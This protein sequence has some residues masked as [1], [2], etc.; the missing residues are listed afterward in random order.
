MGRTT[1]LEDKYKASRTN[2][3]SMEDGTEDRT[4][5]F[6]Y[7]FRNI[8]L[9][10]IPLLLVS[11]IV[12][13]NLSI[14][15]SAYSSSTDS[16]S[17]TLP[18]ACTISASIISTHNAT[19]VNGQYEGDIGNTKVNAYCNDNNGY[20]IYA[21]GSSND[22]DGNTDLVSDINSNYN[23]HT[24]V[25]NAGTLTPSTPS[26]WAMKLSSSGGTYAPT[27]VDGYKSYS[28]IPSTDT[29]V[30]YRTSGTSMDPNTDITGSYFNTTYEIYANT[31]QPAGTYLGKVKYTMTHPYN[32]SDLPT[33]EN[34]FDI[35]G[36]DKITVT[37]PV[38]GETGDY[39]KMQD[40][41]DRI[42]NLAKVYNEL[43]AIQLVDVRDNKLYWVAK[44]ED[45]HCW[46]TQNLD[47]DITSDPTSPSYIALT[48]NNTDLSTDE[49]VYTDS[50][51]IYALKGA[52][53]TYGY[54]YENGIATWIPERDT[55]AY[56]QLSSTTWT[57][58]AN[59]PYSYDRLD[60]NGNPVYPDS[61]VSQALA[62][63]H[64]LSG[65]YYNWTA[66]LASNN[67]AKAT[68]DPVNS[69]CPKGW[70]LPNITN[71]EFGNLLV[72]YGIIET[73]TSQ[74]YLDGGFAKMGTTPLYLV[75]GGSV[76]NGS[77]DYSGSRGRYWSS[78]FLNGSD[79]YRLGF[80]SSIVYPQD[81]GSRGYGYSIRCVAK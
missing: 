73:N 77:M 6:Y 79:A 9:V 15:S 38:T 49:S 63:D 24:G 35:A 29:M 40:M 47:L 18:S 78:T 1:K 50:N 57:D 80:S 4:T 26:S 46:I 72:Q 41:S 53:D 69:I 59:H 67:S 39:Y 22:S 70:R 48:S 16:V 71:K 33:I 2:L 68:G 12:L 64:G 65:N 81:N 28:E 66:T 8:L 76:I 14:H 75:R 55:I 61:N 30:A 74:T 54:T 7:A 44:L 60:N 25:Y 11:G 42:C 13:F 52:G 56:N 10:S 45:N 43:S 32:S 5:F 27:I 17:L 3:H 20:N 58:D 37:D 36:K 31:L 21:I 62:G 19:L 51:T 23:I 34:A